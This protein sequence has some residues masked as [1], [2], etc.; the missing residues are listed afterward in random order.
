MFTGIF[1]QGLT[2]TPFMLLAVTGL[3]ATFLTAVYTFWPAI[4]IFFGP[5]TP[6]ME[7]VREAPRIMTIPLCILAVIS[8]LLGIFPDAIM[9]FLMEV[10]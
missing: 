4:R 2:S 7:K 3:F 10:F 9:H 1:Q 6:N 5:I 8:L